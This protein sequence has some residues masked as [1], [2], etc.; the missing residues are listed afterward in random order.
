MGEGSCS[1]GG[2]DGRHPVSILSFLQHILRAMPRIKP[3]SSWTLFLVFNPLIHN[4]NSS[5]FFFFI[6]KILLCLNTMVGPFSLRPA[7]PS[8]YHSG[9]PLQLGHLVPGGPFCGSQKQKRAELRAR[10]CRHS[11]G[12]DPRKPGVFVSFLCG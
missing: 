2:L 1:D 10:G 7:N 4:G 6:N 8:L 9:P 11:N 12:T 3:A 5:V